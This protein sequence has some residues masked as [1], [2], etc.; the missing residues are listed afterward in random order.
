MPIKKGSA[1]VYLTSTHNTTQWD[2]VLKV[3]NQSSEHA[4]AAHR[5]ALITKVELLG[6]PS[7]STKL[8][9]KSVTDRHGN[10]ITSLWPNGNLSADSVGFLGYSERSEPSGTIWGLHAGIYD[11]RC[12]NKPACDS[13]R[14]RTYKS[15]TPP[16]LMVYEYIV[17][18]VSFSFSLNN[19][20]PPGTLRVTFGFIGGR[21]GTKNPYEEQVVIQL[22]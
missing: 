10:D 14:L 9:P 16:F 13:S 21:S 11:A 2:F 15:P 17:G 20:I 12:D 7:P 4:N 3:W 6:L 1:K 22:T 5:N 18:P 19:F 8:T